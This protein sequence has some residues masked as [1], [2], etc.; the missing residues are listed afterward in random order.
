MGT[1]K[2]TNRYYQDGDKMRLCIK[3]ELH[4]KSIYFDLSDY[5][6]VRQHHW[7]FVDKG[8]PATRINGKYIKLN[9]FICGLETQGERS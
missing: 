2:T 5:D 4:K 9:R 8:V 6:L 3:T 7:T 1:R